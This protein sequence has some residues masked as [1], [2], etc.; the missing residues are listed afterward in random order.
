MAIKQKNNQVRLAC[1]EHADAEDEYHALVSAW[2]LRMLLTSASAFKGFFEKKRGFMDDDL[3]EFLNFSDKDETEIK[4]AQLKAFM[5]DRLK[6]HEK[7]IEITGSLF[8]NIA[9]M[10]KRIP[11]TMIQQQVLALI[12]LKQRYEP[13]KDCFGRLHTPSETHLYAGL[14]KILKTDPTT[15]AKAMAGS[16]ALRSSGL[17][18]LDENYRTGLEIEP[19]DGLVE[20]LM[21]ENENEEALLRHFLVPA[22]PATLDKADYPHA[23]EDVELL[24]GMLTAAMH[25]QEKGVNILLYGT[26]GSGKTELARLLAKSIGVNLFE[27]KTEDEDGDPVNANRRMEGYR[28]C[29]QMLSGD[30]NS[31]ILFDEVEDIFP[32]RGFSLFGMEIKSGENKG[33][34]NKALEENQTPAIWICNKISQIDPAFLR[35]FDYAMELNTP[36]R[37]VRLNIVRSLLADTPVSEPFMQRLAEHEELSPAQ[38]TQAAKVLQRMASD[39]QQA[40]ERVLEKVL[41]NSAKAMGQKPLVKKQLHA[42]HYNLDYLNA[43]IDIPNLVEGL[44][45]NKRG[46]ICFYGTPGTGKTALAGYIAKQLANPL[47]CKRASDILSM[48]VGGTE[49]NIARMFEQARQ[50]DAVLILDEADSLLRDRR[51]ANQSW[52]VT[53]VNELLVQMENFDGLFICSTNLM[54]DLDQASLRR[55]AIKVEF[56]YLKPEQALKM[57]KQECIAAPTPEDARAIA[58]LTN[59]APGD[60]AAVKKRLTILGLDATPDVMI[61]ELQAEVE[62]KQGNVSKSIGFIGS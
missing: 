10:A 40:A 7:K 31:L 38:V 48:W 52:E 43:N 28:F 23:I 21:S 19:M 25:E 53:Q 9:L 14:A 59:L 33:W 56:D 16:A 51:G 47:L 3:R 12:V 49:Q 46:N 4:P 37:S 55:F 20:A 42:T 41:G 36:P 18:K 61:T 57:L 44:K 8:T 5:R 39:D 6:V 32:S 29:Q 11:L 35:R 15:M 45:R 24:Q 27:V 26:P 54:D 60:F 58:M 30:K 22:K 1:A 34:I 50:E 62:V 13:L 2:L 17:I